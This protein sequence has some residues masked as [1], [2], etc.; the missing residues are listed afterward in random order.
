M[1]LS[2]Y[3]FL[4]NFLYF[5]RESKIR[6]CNTL[7]FLFL[8]GCHILHLLG[9]SFT[10]CGG[11]YADNWIWNCCS[12]SHQ[13]G[14]YEGDCDSNIECQSSHFC[15]S[16]NCPNSLGFNSE[17]D[18]CSS[19]QIMSPNYPNSYPDFADETWLLTAPSGSIITL[20]F[21]SFHVRLIV[22]S[23]SRTK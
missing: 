16:N 15:G 5:S 20:Q 8:K 3:V 9:S 13:C 12:S 14:E 23:K 7:K 21:R 17:I 6:N 18:C 11:W 1:F 22:E 2:Q 4:D 19:T 10:G